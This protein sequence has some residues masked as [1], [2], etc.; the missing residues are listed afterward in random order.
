MR[1][2]LRSTNLRRVRQTHRFPFSH[3]RETHW[4]HARCSCK[5]RL[6]FQF[7]G[8]ILRGV[9]VIHEKISQ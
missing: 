6:W 5:P 3:E 1:T 9:S 4:E 7:E 2:L 8:G